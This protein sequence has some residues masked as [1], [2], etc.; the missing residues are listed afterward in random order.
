MSL[1]SIIVPV[2]NSVSTLSRCV[3]S[4]L[5]QTVSDWELLLIDDGSIDE[6][7]KIC[8]EYAV[9]D[10]RIKVL[11]KENGGVSSARNAGIKLAKGDWII[12]LDSDDY[13]LFD[14]L[15]VLLE[16]ALKNGTLVSAAN[17]YVEKNN[18]KFGVCEGKTRIVKNNFCSWYF[19]TCFLRAGATLFHKSVVNK[20]IFDENLNRYEDIKFLF[21][22]MRVERVSYSADFVMVYSEDTPGLSLRVNNIANDYIFCMELDYK[23]F[24]EKMCL[25]RIIRSNSF[26][27]H[28]LQEYMIEKYNNKYAFLFFI[29][30]NI[31]HF[32]LFII[33]FKRLVRK[34]IKKVKLFS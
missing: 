23:S 22:I 10:K 20:F 2:Y 11:H 7:S 15:K 21:D 29:E 25:I 31:S 26:L 13:F 33:R 3:D 17:F 5:N 16:A 24:W 1:I 32:P 14:A 18:K 34:F 27:Y 9:K 12:F 8:D 4:I 30:K 19:Y 6:S 28:E